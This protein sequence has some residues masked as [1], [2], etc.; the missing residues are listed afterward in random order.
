[1]MDKYQL[2][3]KAF[4]SP[5]MQRRLTVKVCYGLLTSLTSWDLS[6]IYKQAPA[7]PHGSDF[8]GGTPLCFLWC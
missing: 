6:E 1:M 2:K 3:A 8:S 7:L 5:A 4:P